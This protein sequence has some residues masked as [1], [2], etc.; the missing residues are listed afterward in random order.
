MDPDTQMDPVYVT[1]L[2]LVSLFEDNCSW[3]L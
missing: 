2:T 1:F 3:I